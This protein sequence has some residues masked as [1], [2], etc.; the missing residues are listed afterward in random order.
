VIRWQRRS[1]S[2]AKNFPS[3]LASCPSAAQ[4]SSPLSWPATTVTYLRPFLQEISSIP[5]RRSPANR[6]LTASTPA[7]TRATMA[8][9]PRQAIRISWQSAVLEQATASHAT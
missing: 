6:S 1:P 3:V 7:H 4:T 9:T 8:P 2:R 5:I